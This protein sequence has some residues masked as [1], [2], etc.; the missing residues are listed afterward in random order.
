MLALRFF[1]YTV[2]VLIINGCSGGE[3]DYSL[4]DV[5]PTSH[6]KFIDEAVEGLEYTRSSD[7]TSLTGR[8]GHYEYKNGDLITFH[9]GA[10]ELGTSSSGSILTPRELAVGA[11]VIEDPKV[12]NRVR[13]LLA[14]DKNPKIGI[15]I[16]AATRKRA[17]TWSSSL[18]FDQ[19]E[20][21]FALAVEVATHGD[22]N[23]SSLPS[24]SVAD[25]HFARS[26]RCAYS[27]GY[28]GAW[29]VPGS[30]E[31]TGFVGAMLQANGTVVVM[32]DG[33]TV[34]DQD[35]SVIYVVGNH[36]INTKSYTFN[37]DVFYYYDR[38][39]ET[40]VDVTD[41]VSIS[42][43]GIN[44]TY[45]HINGSFVNGTQSGSY[46]VQRADASNNAAYRFTG[47]GWNTSGGF[48]IGMIIMDIDPNGKV[49]GLIHYIPDVSIQPQ[50]H[51]TVDFV[52]GE[53][54]ITVDAPDQNTLPL[55]SN[56][57]GSINFNNTS[58][59]SALTWTTVEG[60]ALGS[61]KLDGCQLQAID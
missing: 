50:L 45:D 52:S 34:N 30:N 43:V 21:D 40:L 24:K 15:Q 26:L 22:V 9:V 12:S 57:R 54:T 41:G 18:D 31:T 5:Y 2:I 49:S 46:N 61:V 35:N 19:S 3:A 23:A 28:V 1:V 51:G 53:V 58:E 8:G 13:F 47:F 11:S 55:V 39:Q 37:P 29:K 38:V 25:A 42:G 16:D 14:L 44:K 17:A 33:Q 7:G 36:D 56:V 6:G 4:N 59:E 60:S 20:A 48:P 10:L 27:G 32:G